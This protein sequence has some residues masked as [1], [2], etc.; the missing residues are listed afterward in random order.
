AS[1]VKDKTVSS[2]RANTAVINAEAKIK[3]YPAFATENAV[4][5]GG[6]G[7]EKLSI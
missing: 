7:R 2:N 5:P 4:C 3:G 6:S 1:P